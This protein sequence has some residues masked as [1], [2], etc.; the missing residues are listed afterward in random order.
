[1]KPKIDRK[2]I[3]QND[4]E[5]F[6]HFANIYGQYMEVLKKFHTRTPEEQQ[7]FIVG[8]GKDINNL[9]IALQVY[10]AERKGDNNGSTV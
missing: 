10:V 1:M 7:E 5:A 2:K 8:F 6:E 3:K 4:E 9:L